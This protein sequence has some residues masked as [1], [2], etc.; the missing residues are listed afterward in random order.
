M[1]QSRGVLPFSRQDWAKAMQH[2]IAYLTNDHQAL[3]WAAGCLLAS[4]QERLQWIQIPDRQTVRIILALPLALLAINDIFATALTAAYRMD[5][6]QLAEGLGRFTPG[7]DYTRLIPLMEA[8]PMW[9]HGLWLLAAALYAAAIL[10]LIFGKQPPYVLVLLAIAIEIAA[11]FL[12]RPIIA[13]TGVAANPNPSMIAILIP[14]VLPLSIALLLWR[15]NR[16]L[17]V[18]TP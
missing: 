12:G 4:F 6:L 7:D 18:S 3:C 1:E 2:E 5:A 16:P 15:M 17:S 10:R 13:S 8:V 9:L 14:L 11:Q